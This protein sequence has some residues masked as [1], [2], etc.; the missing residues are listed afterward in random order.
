MNVWSQPKT[1]RVSNHNLMRNVSEVSV[2]APC[3]SEWFAAIL[4]LNDSGDDQDGDGR[5]D[6]SDKDFT[7]CSS[8][9]C[10]Y[11]GHCDY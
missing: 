6:E 4:V 1:G 9:D 11:C 8:Q 10:G 3:R 7:A 5:D 2:A